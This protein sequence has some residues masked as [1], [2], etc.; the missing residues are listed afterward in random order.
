M[1]TYSL[2]K[3]Y[4]DRGWSVFPVILSLDE[5][6]KVAKK[7]AIAW[8]EYQERLPTEVELHKWFDEEKYN[9]IGL[10][11][12]KISRVV[13]VDV[14]S[15]ENKDF[16]SSSTV[17]TISGGWHLYYKWDEEIRNDVGI[18]DKPLDFRGDGGFVVLPGSSLGDQSYSWDRDAGNMYL[19]ILP[20]KIKALLKI[21]KTVAP[22]SHTDIAVDGFPEGH[23]G[24]RNNTAAQVAGIICKNISSKLLPI[25]GYGIFSY[26]NK[27]KCHPSLSDSELRLTWQ[28]IYQLDKRNNPEEPEHV[29]IHRGEAVTAEYE[30]RKLE[31]GNGMGTGFTALDKYFSF[32]PDHLYLLSAPTFHGKTTL[33]LNIAARIASYG[34]NVL[35]C[36]LEQGVFIAPR[37]ESIVGRFPETLSVLESDRTITIQKLTEYIRQKN[38]KIVFIDHLHF[39]K[40]E[41]RGVTEDIDQMMIALQNMAKELHMPVFVIAHVRKLNADREPV[42]D[43][44]RDSSSLSQIPSVVL[45]LYRKRNIT[46]GSTSYLEDHGTFFIAKNRV[47]GKTG[48]LQFNLK[49]GGEFV[50]Y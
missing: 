7:P 29:A 33:A 5:K 24:N 44:L 45:L 37:I 9:G 22:V 28:S 36:S 23:E 41:G 14:D 8:R 31:Y 49:E 4:L 17:K 13:V 20:E 10:I 19:D 6:G 15:L 40:K 27:I 2:A 16:Y 30:K 12:G 48:S 18:E 34:E 26:W 39:I 38:P 11:T 3:T 35:F 1:I 46:E 42:L 25:V 21:R 50:F 43:D 32:L 47:Q